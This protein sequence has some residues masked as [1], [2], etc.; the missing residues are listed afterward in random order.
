MKTNGLVV[1]LTDFGEQDFYVGA[2]KGVIYKIFPKAKIDFISHSVSKFNLPET[3][4]T[5]LN[6]AKEFPEGTTFL[7]VVD[8]EVG[9]WRKE[10]VLQT[11][12]KLNFVAPD[13]GVLT[14][15][16][17]EFG[18]KIIYEILSEKLGKNH[19]TTFHG[20][21]IFAPACAKISK[22]DKLGFLRKISRMKILKIKTANE[23]NG[24]IF[25]EILSI[26][27]F[28]N[29]LSNIPKNWIKNDFGS[30]LLAE[31][32]DKKYSF[33]FYRTYGDSE[34]GDSLNLISSSNFLEFAINQG[35]F[36]KEF[37]IKVGIKVKVK[38][39]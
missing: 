20:R 30:V 24:K 9:T 15:V 10:I 14:L 32:A 21:D 18:T 29:C 12:N 17:Q 11:K 1:M 7:V 35:N 4:F 39:Q 31:I 6:S 3:A 28:G 25:G 34:K 16:A 38:Q 36:A 5:L 27:S 23:K 2:I 8:P 26:D 19:S 33:K 37:G 13:N 22:G